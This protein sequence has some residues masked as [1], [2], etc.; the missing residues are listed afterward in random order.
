[1]D[2]INRRCREQLAKCSETIEESREMIA[3][4]QRWLSAYHN[5]VN[6][7][8]LRNLRVSESDAPPIASAKATALPK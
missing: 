3:R 5:S 6:N 2:E 7:K 1:M 8:K 4:S